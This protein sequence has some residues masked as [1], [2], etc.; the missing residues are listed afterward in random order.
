MADTTWNARSCTTSATR[1]QEH[2]LGAWGEEPRQAAVFHPLQRLP[3]KEILRWPQ[4]PYR[5][6]SG[7]FGCDSISSDDR[8]P[9]VT[10]RLFAAISIGAGDPQSH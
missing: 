2:K 1:R 7:I 4:T 8:H 6:G 9:A 10:G 3:F 5:L